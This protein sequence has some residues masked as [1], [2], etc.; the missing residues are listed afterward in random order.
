MSIRQAQAATRVRSRSALANPMAP[1][2]RRPI[3]AGFRRGRGSRRLVRPG[4]ARPEPGRVDQQPGRFYVS[5][6]RHAAH[7]LLAQPLGDA[8]QPGDVTEPVA[9]FPGEQDGPCHRDIPG[10]VSPER[11]ATSARAPPARRG[12]RRPS[13]RSRAAGTAARS[14]TGAVVTPDQPAP[15]GGARQ[16]HPEQTAERAGE[17]GDRGAEVVMTR[18]RL[19][20]CDSGARKSV[21]RSFRRT[22]EAGA[23]A[24]SGSR[25]PFCR[26]KNCT[27]GRSNSGIQDSSLVERVRSLGNCGLPPNTKLD[28]EAGWIGPPAAA[29][30]DPAG[31]AGTAPASAAPPASRP[32]GEGADISGRCRSTA[33]GGAKRSMMAS[34]PGK[35]F[36]QAHEQRMALQNDPAGPPLALDDQ[37][38]E[39]QELEHVANPLLGVRQ[40]GLALEGLAPPLRLREA[41]ALQKENSRTAS[42][43]RIPRIL[44]PA[45]RRSATRAKVPVQLGAARAAEDRAPESCRSR[46]QIILGA[47]Q[48]RAVV[49]GAAVVRAEAHCL[50]IPPPSL[51]IAAHLARQRAQIRQPDTILAPGSAS[52][53]RTAAATRPTARQ[54]AAGWRG[55]VPHRRSLHRWPEPGDTPVLPGRCHQPLQD[56]RQRDAIGSA[57][58]VQVDRRRIGR[59]RTGQLLL[60]LQRRAEN[61]STG[62][63]CPARGAGRGARV[64]RRH[65][66]GRTPGRPGPPRRADRIWHSAR[67][68]PAPFQHRPGRRPG[69]R[70]R[71]A[72]PP[73]GTAGR[74]RRERPPAPSP[75]PGARGEALGFIRTAGMFT[76]RSCV[77]CR[78]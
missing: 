45:G 71:G 74:D 70:H 56:L 57:E 53:G 1:G 67:P 11:A 14:D 20:H 49:V 27:P 26:L 39:P 31:S 5:H 24:T 43:I 42:A 33:G 30:P 62:R 59:D 64:A 47:M 29:G 35:P 40:Q 16:H 50:A 44:R 6:R 66:H 58:R 15:V 9:Q 13:R 22:T 17:M 63:R 68:L 55:S 25:S 54:S 18:S 46:S 23:A 19:R 60:S 52:P 7:A 75:R 34:I 2:C 61:A 10:T 28:L 77:G 8:Q 32:R 76:T 73:G 21:S 78:C 36:E 72:A 37:G 51:V 41:A 3:S 38:Q 48:V 4:P 12:T 65:D 69:R